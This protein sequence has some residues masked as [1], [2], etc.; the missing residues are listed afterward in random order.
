MAVVRLRLVGS[1]PNEVI[2]ASAE[3]PAR[4]ARCPTALIRAAA[5]VPNL[6]PFDTFTAA[7]K[8]LTFG[9]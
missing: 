7:R 2:N 3:W 9:R 8:V 1:L 6:A 4:V 5:R